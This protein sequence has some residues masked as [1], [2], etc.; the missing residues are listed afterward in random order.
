M[1]TILSA[2]SGLSNMVNAALTDPALVALKENMSN[3]ASVAEGYR[4]DLSQDEEQ[5]GRTG[6]SQL[7]LG[8]RLSVDLQALNQATLQANDGIAIT[9]I[10]GA[11]LN[12]IHADLAEMQKLV[13]AS[14]SGSLSAED[15]QNLQEEARKLQ[16]AI[17]QKIHSTRYNEIPLLASTRA[18]LL[19]AGIE[20][21]V[22]NTIALKDLSQALTPVDTSSTAGIEAGESS[23]AKDVS[24]VQGL[25]RQMAAK[26]GEFVTAIAGLSSWAAAR[27]GMGARID[28]EQ[29]AS[30]A[31]SRIAALIRGNAAQAFHV[32]ANQ[33]PARVAQLV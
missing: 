25:Q 2:V 10:G 30:Q 13:Q 16:A 18:M 6:A 28:S 19:Q 33:A 3:A 11:A 27:T 15:R 4:V 1:A 22:Q 21:G 23:L 24:M 12:D 32:Q 20:S 8:G 7:S 29:E 26:E 31:A 17:E 9:Q 14:R 5:A